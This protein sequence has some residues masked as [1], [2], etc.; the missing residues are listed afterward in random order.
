[1]NNL[2]GPVRHFTATKKDG[3]WDIRCGKPD[4]TDAQTLTRRTHS[5][6]VIDY[7]DMLA[8]NSGHKA[9]IHFDCRGL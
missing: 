6:E 8:E 2:N 3:R 1:M 9:S 7:C 5:D 4:D